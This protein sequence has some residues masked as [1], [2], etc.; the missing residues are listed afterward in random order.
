MHFK[1]DTSGWTSVEFGDVVS[2]VNTVSKDLIGDGISR[3]LGLE[4]LD[5]GELTIRR[6]GDIENGVTFTK[7][8]SPGQTLFGKRRA[9]Q[10]KVAFA[11]FR[12]VCSGDIL[13]FQPKGKELL[14]KFLPFLVMSEGFFS[15][16]LSTSAGSLSP[17]TR[18]SDLAK[19]RFL[20]PPVTQ[21]Q[22]IADLFWS[23]ENSI[24]AKR[25]LHE[26]LEAT[27]ASYVREAVSSCESF[28]PLPEVAEVLDSMRVPVN[29]ADRNRRKGSVPYYG[30]GGQ[31]GWIDEAIFDEDLVLVGEDATLEVFRISGPAWVNNHAH[32]LRAKSV[33]TDWLYH[34][35]KNINLKAIATN[36]TRLKLTQGALNSIQI[37]IP[38]YENDV[39]SNI[40][41]IEKALEFNGTAIDSEQDM[42]QALLQELFP[43]AE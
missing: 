4:H 26:A 38:N 9:Y 5:K 18:W 36:G 31:V 30:A 10:R 21:Q 37:P 41:D 43:G 22:E 3:F 42:R 8:V 12:A 29:A 35:I 24:N 20:L 25:E 15:K 1:L 34:A 28:L 17:R 14:E 11:D 40:Q 32:V 16:A 39:V 33:S 7:V 6:F 27:L 13:T 23:L 19:Y 2:N